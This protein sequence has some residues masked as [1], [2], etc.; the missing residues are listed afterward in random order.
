MPLIRSNVAWVQGGKQSAKGT[1][2]TDVTGYH[3]RTRL[4]S[5]DR[6]SPRA[7]TAVFAETD[8]S[9]DAPNSE[10]VSGGAEGS[11]GFGVRDS[12]FHKIAEMVIGTA[13]L[14]TTGSTNYVHTIKSDTAAPVTTMDYYSIQQMLGNTLWERFSDMVANEFTVTVEAGGFMTAT[15]GMLGRTPLRLTSAPTGPAEAADSVYQFNDAAVSIGGS[16]SGLVRSMNLTITNNLQLLQTDDV[17]PYDVAVGSREVTLGFDMLFE[18][19]DHYNLFHYGSTSGTTQSAA[20]AVTDLNFLF[21]KGANNSIEFDFDSVNYEEFPVA[22]DTGGEPII[23][24]ARVRARRNASG[25]VKIIVK[26]QT[27]T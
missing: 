19:L 11:F 14:T 24:S 3:W 27:A 17:V 20:T 18:T 23:V 2:A 10:K 26:N 4:A 12:F 6:I 9:R 15:V 1:P 21:T 13:S 25:L 16:A 7:E 8:G 5:D 22:P